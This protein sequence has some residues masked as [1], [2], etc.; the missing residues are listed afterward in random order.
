MLRS[1]KRL[2]GRN[3]FRSPAAEKKSIDAYN[4]WSE[5]YDQQPGNLMLD[6]DERV[7]T[8]L[9]KGVDIKNKEVADIGCGTGRHWNKLLKNGPS[10]LTGFDVSPGML[11]GLRGKFPGASTHQI[12]DNLFSFIPNA[13]YDVIVSTLTVA[14]VEDIEEAL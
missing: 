5:Q 6:L 10:G 12:T 11:N 8:E 2:F 9:L 13:T 1:L 14:H 4:L 3:R 7:F